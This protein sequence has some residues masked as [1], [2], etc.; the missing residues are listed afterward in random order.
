MTAAG[1]DDLVRA[2][3]ARVLLYRSSLDQDAVVSPQALVEVRELMR[4]VA[5]PSADP[6]AVRAVADLHF[7]RSVVL[8]TERGREDA[9]IAAA[10]ARYLEP[11]GQ[12]EAVAEPA[13]R[14]LAGLLAQAG[15]RVAAAE[16]HRDAALL[17]QALHAA[18]AA[19]DGI[20][21][22]AGP[23]RASALALWGMALRLRYERGGDPADLD[24]AIG[25]FREADAAVGSRHPDRAAVLSALAAS[26]RERH[27][28]TGG[29]EDLLEGV[30]TARAAVEAG[31][32]DGRGGRLHNLGL[33]LRLRHERTGERADLEEAIAV[34]REAVALTPPDDRDHS[35]FQQGLANAWDARFERTSATEDLQARI[36]ALEAAVDS[37]A[38][39]ARTVPGT[40]DDAAP[41]SGGRAAADA[42]TRA[43]ALVNLA[44]ALTRRYELT[45]DDEDADRAEDLLRAAAA[46]LPA[47]H[48]RHAVIR[49]QLGLVLAARD[50]PGA[51]S[52]LRAAALHASAA[53]RLRLRAARGW[54]HAAM[55]D[56]RPE[57]AVTAYS[58]A[59]ARLPA[60]V[61]R[62][63]HFADAEH[64]LGES[65][66]LAGDAAA[67]ALSAGDPAL[68]LGLLELGRGVLLGQ[69]MKNGDELAELRV[70][71]PRTADRLMWLRT[72]LDGAGDGTTSDE[73]H[74]LA[75]EWDRLLAEVRARRGFEDF[76]LPPRP[77]KLLPLGE[78][79]PVVVVNVSRYRCDAI[80]VTAEGLRVIPLPGLAL[81]GLVHRTADLLTVLDRLQDPA[82][83]GPEAQVAAEDEID[84][85][86]RWL[87]DT[88]TGP[89]LDGLGITG[90]S[91]T[92]P[93][94]V[95]WIPTGPLAFLPLH[96]AG[97]HE[98][99]AGRT[100]LDRT[101]SSYTPSLRVLARSRRPGRSAASFLVV[102]V[103]EAPAA[104]PLPGAAEE[105]AVL[106]GLL[107]GARL[108]TG[109]AATR[110]A[111]VAALRDHAWLH[112][113][114]H[115]TA[116]PGTGSG[117]RLIV[118]DHLDHPL[119]VA[120]ISRLDLAG[121]ELAY[122]SACHT[123]R[124][125]FTAVDE[126]LHLAGGLQIAGFRHV[127]AT[128]WGIED[129][130]SARIA[131][132]VYVGL[133]APRPMADRAAYAVRE[134]VRDMRDR[135]PLTPS[136][137]AAHLHA[138][139]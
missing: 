103:P 34:H 139:P 111:V 46:V 45:T 130:V 114:G 61:P 122:L 1:R 22:R 129:T 57:E 41:D 32:P 51:E 2:L 54:G 92:R 40:G 120:G 84:G 80:A 56:G 85:H 107:P 93:P 96:A 127:V 28:R 15:D 76:M 123:A 110:D 16:R 118:H 126:A 20:P 68:A 74:V 78:R 119:T 43:G 108:L 4:L 94:R 21:V 79:G 137:W 138:G 125:G 36:H 44:S 29:F 132:R 63:L 8:G 91:K 90:P 106:T 131:E 75:A 11:G 14:H 33:A 7:C 23:V 24:A 64:A 134:A 39:T 69:G 12:P 31:G 98:E 60:L 102:A 10:L 59:I 72:R 71:A 66:L 116:E 70:H 100:V 89:V 53:P 62:H 115:A 26:L 17:R 105:A 5:D 121:A 81:S 42:L 6:E 73:R 128:L 65:G 18:R 83:A 58:A 135:Y 19:V 87:W 95:W 124:T 27:E 97:H 99:A 77:E 25:A 82:G 136:L 86:L 30:R 13:D 50:R 133:G 9:V 109:D 117:S 52:C 67:C 88:V 49:Y 38:R 101:A 104:P 48:A 47:Q 37:T 113:C 55:K 35:L 112:F 3:G